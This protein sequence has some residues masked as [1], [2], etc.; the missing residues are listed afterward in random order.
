MA[1]RARIHQFLQRKVHSQ[2]PIILFLVYPP[3]DAKIAYDLGYLK[4][5][6]ELPF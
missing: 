4:D 2:N 5:W 1:L 3:S 6:G